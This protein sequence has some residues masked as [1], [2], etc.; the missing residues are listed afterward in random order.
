M[1]RG[2]SLK[3]WDR[4][5]SKSP[6]FEKGKFNP[7]LKKAVTCTIKRGNKRMHILLRL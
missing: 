7:S 4:E 1:D 6:S 5:T 3:V 2:G